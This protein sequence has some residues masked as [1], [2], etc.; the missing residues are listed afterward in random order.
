MEESAKKQPV[1]RV[2]VCVFKIS[3]CQDG[4]EYTRILGPE[5]EKVGAI[6]TASTTIWI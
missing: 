3:D 2:L 5:R 1:K 6:G 4:L